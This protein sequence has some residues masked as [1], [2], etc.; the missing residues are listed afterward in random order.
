[1]QVDNDN[2]I[3][4]FDFI[5]DICLE[6]FPTCKFSGKRKEN[7]ECSYRKQGNRERD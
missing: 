6:S 2:G 1:M 3:R 4:Y 7:G 5:N